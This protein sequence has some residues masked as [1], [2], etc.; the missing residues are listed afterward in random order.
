M[1]EAKRRGTPEERAA[2]ARAKIE[3]LRPAQLVC[4][5]CKTAFAQFDTLDVPGLP[6]IDAVFGGECPGCGNDV[7]VFKGA[8]EAV[9]QAMIAWEKMLGADA[10]LGY[11]S[12]D[13]R[14][15]PFEPEG[16]AGAV[17]DKPAGTLH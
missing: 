6:G 8:P 16:A 7:V 12:S 10:Q 2:Q 9:A 4:G 15:V 3:A 1:G 17:P 14:H 11:Q 13:G 5:H